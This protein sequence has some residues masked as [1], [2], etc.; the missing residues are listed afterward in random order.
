MDIIGDFDG[1]KVAIE[2]KVVR[3]LRSLIERL[4]YSIYEAHHY[5]E[6]NDIDE[7]II[8][9]VTFDVD[10]IES[11][12]SILEPILIELPPVTMIIGIADLNEDTGSVTNFYT[13][14]QF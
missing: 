5:V 2:V 3:Q 7:L 12:R 8:V 10:Q 1:R 14:T 9:L 4:R 6:K 13:Y 11:I